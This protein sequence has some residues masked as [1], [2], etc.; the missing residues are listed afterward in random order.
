M[1]GSGTAEEEEVVAM[2]LVNLI[3]AGDAYGLAKW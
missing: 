3:D 1:G 2:V